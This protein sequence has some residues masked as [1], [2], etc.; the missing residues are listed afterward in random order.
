MKDAKNSIE[1]YQK[2]VNVF[3]TKQSYKKPW[4]IGAT[5]WLKFDN[6][7]ILLFPLFR[8]VNK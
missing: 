3:I 5:A 1:K 2:L 6:S 4:T 8:V 7:A